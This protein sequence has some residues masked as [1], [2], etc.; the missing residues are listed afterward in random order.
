MTSIFRFVNK[1]AIYYRLGIISLSHTPV[2]VPDFLVVN[3]HVDELSSARIWQHKPPYR[4]IKYNRDGFQGCNIAF[5]IIMLFSQ[6][7]VRIDILITRGKHLHDG[8][9]SQGGEWGHKTSLSPPLC[10]AVPVSVHTSERSCCFVLKV[11]IF[12]FLRYSYLIVHS[13]VSSNVYSCHLIQLFLY[14]CLLWSQ[15]IPCV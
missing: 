2:H 7:S 10:I 14:S 4:N 15:R 3:V 6:L 8:I 11:S 13:S 9:I 5:F 12:L 1:Q